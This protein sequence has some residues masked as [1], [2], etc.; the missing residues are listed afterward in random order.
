MIADDYPAGRAPLARPV[1]D[2]PPVRLSRTLSAG[3][4]R[5][6]ARAERILALRTELL[7]TQP[8]QGLGTVFAVMSPFAGEGRSR[9]AADLA[10]SFARLRDNT[11][12]VD[13][14]MRRPAQHEL[15]DG[16]NRTDGLFKSI[17]TGV[18][19]VIQP[20]DG[21]P[22]MSVLTA[23]PVSA[24]NP[25]DLL[26]DAFFEGMVSSWRNHYRF[27]IIDTPP[28]AEYA[29]ALAVAHAAGQAL[30][31]CRAGHTSYDGAKSMLRRLATT[32]ARVMG[33]VVNHF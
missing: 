17:S 13:A 30:V 29:D 27:V 11:L 14:D 6:S 9:L 18:Q 15:F 26:S 21:L 2:G 32:H 8:M 25:L 20:M 10:L 3:G 19:P 31:V 28:V 4:G 1:A 5:Y 22:E 33:A 12:L 16:A 24:A 23:G 7:L